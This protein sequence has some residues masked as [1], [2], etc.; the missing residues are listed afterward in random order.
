MKCVWLS[1]LLIINSIKSNNSIKW[2][3]FFK[4]TWQNWVSAIVQ[5]YVPIKFDTDRYII[6]T[7]V[8]Y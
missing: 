7:R 4:N 5:K 8:K 2:I 6:D 3:A 1:I